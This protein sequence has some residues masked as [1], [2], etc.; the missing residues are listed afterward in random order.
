MN[1]AT[2][3]L[4]KAGEAASSGLLEAR[5][6]AAASGLLEDL[7]GRENEATSQLL[8]AG[9]EAARGLLGQ[10]QRRQQL[11]H[12]PRRSTRRPANCSRG[13]SCSARA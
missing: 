6:D 9:E 4:L 11:A 13:S 1:E 7:E 5:A 10:A 12:H 3:R 8:K 2:S